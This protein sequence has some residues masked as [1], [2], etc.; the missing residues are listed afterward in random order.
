MSGERMIVDGAAFVDTAVNWIVS[1]MQSILQERGVC[2]LMLA[3]GGT[4]MPIYRSMATLDLPWGD[5]KLYFGDER[6]VPSDHSDSNYRAVT[7]SLFPHGIPEN[8][9]L[10]RM[11]GEDDPDLAALEYEGLLPDRIDILLLGMGGDGH[12]ASL[13]PGSPALNESNRRVLP[14]IGS[15]PPPRRLSITPLVIHS[16][17]KVLV[18]AEGGNKADAV[19]RALEVGDVPV[20]LA[21]KGDWLMD[22]AAASALADG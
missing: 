18:L 7:E 21:S 8:L 9:E 20:A 3:G 2:H 5:L 4:P 10:H 15:K 19:H 11:R 12:T 14:V 17:R 16:A 1:A 13:F 22:R 6:C